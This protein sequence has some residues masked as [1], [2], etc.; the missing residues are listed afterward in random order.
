MRFTCEM[1]WQFTE[2]QLFFS[3]MDILMAIKISEEKS[4]VKRNVERT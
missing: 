2:T 4:E 3:T 1:F